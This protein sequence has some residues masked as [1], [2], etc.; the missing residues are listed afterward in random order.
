MTVDPELLER[1]I[2]AERSSV[3]SNLS[4]ANAMRYGDE[5]A[6][7]VWLER[8]VE[9]QRNV[10]K[11]YAQLVDSYEPCRACGRKVKTPCHDA[12]G[13]YEGG[14]WDGSCEEVIRGRR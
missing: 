7:L 14:P 6:R 9:A 13:Y 2:S 3:A 12:E 10:V 5:G 8:A 4:T 11:L 1:E